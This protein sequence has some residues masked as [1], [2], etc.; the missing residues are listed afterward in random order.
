MFPCHKGSRCLLC[1]L[2]GICIV[3]MVAMELSFI[4][5]EVKL[6]CLFQYSTNKGNVMS[7]LWGEQLLV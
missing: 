2:G 7:F 4:F 6:L 1:W 3:D 5:C